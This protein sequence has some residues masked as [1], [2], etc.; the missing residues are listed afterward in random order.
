[1][2]QFVVYRHSSHPSHQPPANAAP[3]A[4]VEAESPAAA[5]ELVTRSGYIPV[6]EGQHLSALPRAEVP[7]EDWEIAAAMEF[8]GEVISQHY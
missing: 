7:D 2:T 5:I 1:V 6:R 3:V 8:M 4:V